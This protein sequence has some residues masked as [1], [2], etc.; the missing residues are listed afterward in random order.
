MTLTLEDKIISIVEKSPS[1]QYFLYRQLG[2]V[3]ISEITKVITEL[4]RR[5]IIHVIK[6]R[7]NYRTGLMI[8]IYSLSIEFPERNKLDIDG[9][10]AG[11]IS[12]R[13][14]EYPFLAR[15]L[16][17]PGTNA[18]I[19]DIGSANSPLTKTISKFGNKKWHVIGIDIAATAPSEKFDSLSLTRMDARLLG[20]RDEVFD[21][22]IC[23]STIEHIGIPSD[24]Y[25]I[26]QSDELGDM[27]AISEIYRVLKK[28]GSV[29]A[30]LPYGNKIKKQDHRIYSKSSLDNITRVFSVIRKEFYRYDDGKWKKC[31][32]QSIA[33]KISNTKGI[34][35][36]FHS[37]ICACLLLRNEY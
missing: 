3:K 21:Q 19:L 12:E 13:L 10:L 20:F 25:N 28:G 27:R 32:N 29:I 7:K 18:R 11:I 9:L 1:D 5:N 31:K 4:Q 26:R 23:I 22:I 15:N 34:P 16:I 36:Y 14:V 30:T 2:T 6:H 17:S 8:P 37:R 35:P 24:Y 33:D